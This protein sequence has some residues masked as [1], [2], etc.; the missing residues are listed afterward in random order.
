[1]KTREQHIKDAAEA[2][3]NLNTFA[4]VVSVL[5]GGNI[6]GYSAAAERIIKIC[7][8]EQQLYLEKYD[9]AVSAAAK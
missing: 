1:M 8:R 5:E 6:C 2:H 9:R 4:V 3:T 7:L